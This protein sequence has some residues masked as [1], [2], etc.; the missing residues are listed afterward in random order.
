M[1]NCGVAWWRG[2]CGGGGGGGGGGGCSGVGGDQCFSRLF[3][4]VNA[5]FINLRRGGIAAATA[6]CVEIRRGRCYVL[7]GLVCVIT[8]ANK[9]IALK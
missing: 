4:G 8:T 6:Q 7:I 2:S 3:D 9:C 5:T 1:W